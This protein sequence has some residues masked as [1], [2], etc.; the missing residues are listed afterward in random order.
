MIELK[1]QDAVN[2][3]YYVVKNKNLFRDFSAF[4]VERRGEKI[5]LSPD[6]ALALLRNRKIRIAELRC[7]ILSVW[8]VLLLAEREGAILVHPGPH[9]VLIVNNHEGKEGEQET[10][11]VAVNLSVFEEAVRCAMTTP[12]LDQHHDFGPFIRML[13]PRMVLRKEAWKEDFELLRH[14]SEIATELVQLF[15]LE[16][17]AIWDRVLSRDLSSHC[18][19]EPLIH[20]GILLDE[21]LDHF[22]TNRHPAPIFPGSKDDG[23]LLNAFASSDPLLPRRFRV[24]LPGRRRL[25]VNEQNNEL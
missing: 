17:S 5:S 11:P 20:G 25:F 7:D 15:D 23:W 24:S 22:A 6:R 1:G 16:K 19:N 10:L 21:V 2:Q 18:E 13:Y 9:V 14:A 8:D 4:A 3:A 12:I